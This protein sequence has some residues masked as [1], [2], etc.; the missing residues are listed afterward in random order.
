MLDV[1]RNKIGVILTHLHLIEN[2]VFRIRKNFIVNL[3]TVK[4]QAIFF[5]YMKG[6]INKVLVNMEFP[7]PGQDLTIFSKN[8]IIEYGYYPPFINTGENYNGR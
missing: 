7:V 3:C 2:S 5:K 6:R 1:P 8:L 4:S